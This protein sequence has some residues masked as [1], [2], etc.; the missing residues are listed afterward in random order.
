[1]TQYRAPHVMSVFLL[2]PLLWRRRRELPP[3]QK[4]SARALVYSSYDDTIYYLEIMNL[5]GETNLKL[6]RSL[7]EDTSISVPDSFFP[8]AAAADGRGNQQAVAWVPTAWGLESSLKTYTGA[9]HEWLK[10]CKNRIPSSW[11]INYIK[12]WS[13][14]YH[15]SRPGYHKF[16]IHLP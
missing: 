15:P 5:D 12:P 6:K 7:E 8:V 3:C 16:T 14:Y 9:A 4:P 10:N 1:M 11:S 13:E 2:F